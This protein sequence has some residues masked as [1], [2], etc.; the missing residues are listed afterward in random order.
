MMYSL[1]RP[2][3]FS[4]APERAH[5]LTLSLL[6]SAH[7][8]G[9]MRQK[10]AP[11]PVTCMGIQFPNPVGLAA[12][13]D[14]NGAYID[15]LAALGFGFIEIG[16]IT[17]KP[18][19]GNPKP[20]LFRIPEAKAIINRMGFNNDGVDQLVENVKAA[21]FKGVLGINI[22]KNATTPV[23][24]AVSDYLICLEKVYAYASYITVNISSPN[25]QNL[26]SLQSG[27]ALTE[28]LETLKKRQ[29]E[30]AEEYQHYVPLVLKVAPDLE[31]SDIQFIA[32]QL[33][34]FK[35]DGLIVTNTTL[36]REGVEG[37]AFGD[38]AG[39]LSGAPV[40]EKSTAC[41]AAFSKLLKDEIPL[42]GVGGILSGDQA[43]AKQQAGASLVQIYSG[44]IY[45][46]PTLIKDC[47]DAMI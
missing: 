35:I 14:K 20:R 41:L 12:G 4:L 6:K 16:T 47:V 18:Q 31:Q 45:T 22:G 37:L 5:E 19:A 27:H 32:S 33:L 39:G 17:P 42:I 10:I 1:A 9:A 44:M 46:G 30:L 8:V 2:L 29:L 11:K 38:E 28:L 7:K 3:L 43:V 26:R 24:D 25:T 36:S 21:K 13:L 23:E 34:E 40:F 15:A